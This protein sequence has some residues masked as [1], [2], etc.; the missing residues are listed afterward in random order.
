MIPLHIGVIAFDTACFHV[1]SY[2]SMLVDTIG[3]QFVLTFWM[4]TN[5]CLLQSAHAYSCDTRS[6]GFNRAHL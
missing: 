4:R 5:G 6:Y 2:W 1:Y 3:R